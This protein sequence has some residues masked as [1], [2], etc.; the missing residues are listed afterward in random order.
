MPRPALSASRSVDVIDFL[1][2]FPGPAY[3]PFGARKLAGFA[4]DQPASPG[5]AREALFRANWIAI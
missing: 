2:T 1:A 4:D 3:G 5:A